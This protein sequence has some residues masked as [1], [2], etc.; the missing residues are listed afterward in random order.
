MNGANASANVMKIHVRNNIT[1]ILWFLFLLFQAS[2]SGDKQMNLSGRLI[3]A[4][5]GTNISSIDLQT[6]KEEVLYYGHPSSLT[7]LT[8]TIADK[9]LFT[10]CHG[11]RDPNCLLKEFDIISGTVKTLR[12][13]IMPTY[14]ARSDSVF[15]YDAAKDDGEKWLFVGQREALD[16]AR[17]VTKA[18][19]ALVLPNGL[20]YELAAP[21]V[22]VSPNEVALVGEDE[23][24]W[25]YQISQSRLIPTE[26]KYSF[27]RAWRSQ[28]G[29]LICYDWQAKEFYQIDL[30]TKNTEKLPLL[31]GARGPV[32]IPKYDTLI[33]GKTRLHWL[34]SEMPEIFAYSFSTGE[35]VKLQ[36]PATM[37]SGIWFE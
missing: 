31:K 1:S 36:S 28:M 14:V 29:Q 16:N 12:T 18:P 15:F 8:R 37:S 24:L 7:Y 5:G 35:K 20:L 26:I 30:K 9:F 6:L 25:I 4:N 17:K 23:G 32:Y 27:P 34:I 33:Y 13:G 10:D 22:E 19:A 11:L 3:Y 2:C 21:V